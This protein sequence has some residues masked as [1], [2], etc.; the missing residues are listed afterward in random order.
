MALKGVA[1]WLLSD[2]NGGGGGDSDNIWK[3][4]VD[5]SGDLSWRKSTSTTTPETQNIKGPKGDTGATGAQ[6]PKGDTGEIGATG[7]QGP[8]GDTGAQGPKGDTG[9]TGPQGPQGPKGDTGATGATGPQGPQ[10]PKGDTGDQGPKGEDGAD[11]TQVIANPSGTATT[12][13]TKLQID[14]DIYSIPQG[15]SITVDDEM[16]SSSENPVQNKVITAALGGKVD[17]E[18]GK[19]LSTEDYTTPEKTKLSGIETGAEVNAIESISVNGTAVSPDVNKNVAL[20]IMTNAVNDLLNYYLKSETYTKTEVNNLI[21]AITTIDMQV[22]QQLPTTDISTTTIYLVP[23]ATAQT[24]NTY[25]EYIC[26]DTT[27]TPATWEKIGDTQIDLSNYVQKSSTAGLIKND[28][29]I[30]ETTYATAAAVNAILNGATIDSFLDV[31]TA[32]ANKV[33]KVNGKGLSTN[34]YDNTSKGI[35]DNI[36]DNVIANTKLIS[37]TVGWSGKNKLPITLAEVK[38]NNIT[39]TWSGNAYTLNGVTATFT[40]DGSGYITNVALSNQASETTTITLKS[41]HVCDYILSNMILNGCVTGGSGSTFKL[42]IYDVTESTSYADF[43]SG[44]AIPNSVNGHTINVVIIIYSGSPTSN[45][46]IKPMLRDANI[47]DDTYE[48]YHGSTAVDWLSYA[49]TGAVNFLKNNGASK[50]ENGVTITVNANKTVTVVTESGGATADTTLT[51][52]TYTATEGA[53]FNGMKLSGCPSGGGDDK[54]RLVLQKNSSPWSPYANDLGDGAIISG[55]DSDIVVYIRVKSGTVITTPITFKPM[56]SYPNNTIYA[57]HAM[58]NEELT[59]V[60]ATI[61][62]VS[63]SHTGTA[64]STGVRKEVISVNS[65]EY[66]VDGSAYMEQSVTLSTSTTT[67][68]TFTNAIIADGKM[69]TM[70]SPIWYLVPDDM[71]TTTGVCTITLPKWS[72]AETIGVRLYVR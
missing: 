5:A 15:G 56:I 6:G 58:T 65:V 34:D 1:A 66:E 68:V 23:K 24:Q 11:G 44:I 10:G 71:V 20:T 70:A 29:T 67:T 26:L 60:V 36:Q 59:E 21:A 4:T 45:I 64:S 63:V 28:G 16:S 12:D 31:E 30:D 27:T 22:V 18:S 57:P 62:T 41:N 35:V 54:Y 7:P 55:V 48:P 43:G 39:G 46:N 19:G 69:I 33:D 61:P 32:L 2:G 49:K 8:K 42:Q 47:L 52:K 9:A 38:A 17:T 3:P 51:L 25:D 72:T 40:V 37:D 14:N 53:K 13:L 50:T